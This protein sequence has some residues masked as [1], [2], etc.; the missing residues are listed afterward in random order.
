MV[1]FAELKKIQK[2][3]FATEKESWRNYR[4]PLAFWGN[5]NSSSQIDFEQNR[6]A[7]QNQD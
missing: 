2:Q 3:K 5:S 7:I 6:F 1:V 4:Q